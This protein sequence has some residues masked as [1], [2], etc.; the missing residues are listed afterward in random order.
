MSAASVPSPTH[1]FVR[2]V[3]PWDFLNRPDRISTCGIYCSILY[4]FN[5]NNTIMTA[6]RNDYC[7]V[8][9]AKRI[10][11]TFCYR[12]EMTWRYR[13]GKT[14]TSTSSHFSRMAGGLERTTGRKNTT[15][16]LQQLGGNTA[17]CPCV[18]AILYRGRKPHSPIF[19]RLSTPPSTT[20]QSKQ[21]E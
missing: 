8:Y 20:F 15:G 16:K 13:H 14:K 17:I 1:L 3:H 18:I 4:S 7:G 21:G 6:Q 11:G 19:L 9:V 10:Q 2:M 12:V 5:Y